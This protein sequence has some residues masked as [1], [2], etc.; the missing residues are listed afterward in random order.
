MPGIPP[1]VNHYVRHTRDGRHYKTGE[2]E[3]FCQW[4]A[5]YARGKKIRADEY[6]VKI[7]IT[8]GHKQKGDLDNFAK[9]VL[10][11]MVKCGV[12]DSD[13]KVTV[14]HMFKGRDRD[15]P[16]TDVTVWAVGPVES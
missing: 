7:V 1:S 14:L 10:D 16:R 13:A 5:I 8:L 11:S 9:V 3:S 12:I 4:L 6:G 15:N 2:A